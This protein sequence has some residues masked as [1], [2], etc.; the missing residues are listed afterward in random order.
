MSYVNRPQMNEHEMEQKLSEIRHS[1]GSK[2]EKWADRISVSM[3]FKPKV[4]RQV[5]ERW[6]EDGHTWVQRQGFKERLTPNEASRMPWWCPR[7]S[8]SMNH[9]FDRKFYFLRGWCYNCNI[10]VEGEMRLNGTFE[11]FEK[12]ILRQNEVSFL[13]DKIEQHLT[14]IKEFKEPTV[15]FEDGRYEVIASKD[16]FQGT[17]EDL[18]RDVDFMLARLEVIQK[19]SDE[20]TALESVET[21]HEVSE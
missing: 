18:L 9:R 2:V 1:V 7:C 5:G 15:Y 11:K 20:E 4:D 8:K 16:Q 3:A 17:F 13:K 19:E 21:V 6:D 14:Y 12:Q 10:D